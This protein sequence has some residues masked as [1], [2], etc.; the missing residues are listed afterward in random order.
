MPD[1]IR[2][3][4]VGAGGNTRDRHVPGLR[5]QS[6]V[7]L[8]G[9]AN[10]TPE[11]SRRAAAEFGVDRAYDSWQE[12]VAD[13]GID[14]VVIGTWPNLHAAVT[15]AALAA[16]KHVLCEA[17]MALDLADALR[18]L[19]A[20]TAQPGLVAQLVPSPLGLNV[21]R[22]VRRLVADGYLGT[23]YSLRIAGGAR[24]FAS[25]G[26]PIGPRDQRRFMGVSVMDLGLWYEPS[27]RW[28]G[29]AASVFAQ[30]EQTVAT[31]QDPVTGEPRPVDQPD[32]LEIVARYTG[33]STGSFTF[34]QVQGLAPGAGAWLFGSDGTLHFDLPT[35]QLE[36]GRAGEAA[37]APVDLGDERGGWRVEA[38]FIG[39]I[40][41][42]EQ[43]AYTTFA[44]GVRYMAFTDAVRRSAESG[45]AVPVAQ[46][47]VPGAG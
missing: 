16:G 6:G 18:M 46:L 19:E 15:L 14:A 28:W 17:R 38:E 34:T 40:R 47:D 4:F 9:V 41:G 33:G 29:H 3:G 10:S 45:T 43:V 21:D 5:E 37:L 12:L 39:A 8:A 36:A 22:T 26:R 44:D 42:E 25:P 20:S 1:E 7:R 11:S 30:A 27:L 31:R 35:Q 2:I 24:Q 13:P 23:P 32:H